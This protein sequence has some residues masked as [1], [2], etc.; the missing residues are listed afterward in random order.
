MIFFFRSLARNSVGVLIITT[1]LRIDGFRSDFEEL[2]F[3][4]NLEYLLSA[5]EVGQE[6]GDG[7]I[8]AK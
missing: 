8:S 2:Y 6:G 7:Q 4:Q 3:S 5:M 1:S